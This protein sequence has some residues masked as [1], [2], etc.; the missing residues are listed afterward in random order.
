MLQLYTDFIFLIL[1]SYVWKACWTAPPHNLR[2]LVSLDGQFWQ[3]AAGILKDDDDDNPTI[4]PL[5]G[6]GSRPFWQPGDLFILL[7]DF[8]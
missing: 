6:L 3:P 1:A 8:G 4:L 5:D 7:D 2:F